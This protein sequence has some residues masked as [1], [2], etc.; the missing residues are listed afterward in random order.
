MAGGAV[1]INN[2]GTWWTM[3]KS[4]QCK[5]CKDKPIDYTK[6]DIVPR[7]FIRGFKDGPNGGY[8][9][10]LLG[11]SPGEFGERGDAYFVDDEALC[12]K[13]NNERLSAWEGP[14]KAF[15]DGFVK[16]AKGPFDYGWCL[17]CVAQ[18]AGVTTL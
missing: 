5:L 17:T 4:G 12:K 10:D 7:W 15:Y 3:K 18:L 14:S 16:G 13:C 9:M 2:D 8:Y 11:G 1:S 6:S